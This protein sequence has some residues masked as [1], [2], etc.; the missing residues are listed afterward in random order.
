MFG[1]PD[2]DQ[3]IYGSPLITF[4]TF[5][6]YTRRLFK[7]LVT[8]RIQLNARNLLNDTDL[9]HQLSAPDG[10][11]VISAPKQPRSFIITNT[12]SF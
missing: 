9:I 2:I 5:A 6:G 8:W 10:I 3:P 11:F 7:D 12:F 4:D 1:G